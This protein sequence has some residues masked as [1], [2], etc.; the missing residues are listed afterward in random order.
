MIRYIVNVVL[1]LASM[2]GLSYLAA[3]FMVHIDF[4]NNPLSAGRW[5]AI[6]Q[7]GLL[8]FAVG[9]GTVAAAKFFGLLTQPWEKS[10]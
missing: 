2:F 1:T 7:L 3:G 4:N 8:M 9:A 6:A 5:L 10:E